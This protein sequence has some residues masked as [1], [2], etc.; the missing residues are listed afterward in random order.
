MARSLSC[1]E[2]Q[3][4]ITSDIFIYYSIYINTLKGIY[5]CVYHSHSIYKNSKYNILYI[6]I[7]YMVYI[8]INKFI[9]V[10]I[11]ICK[12]KNICYTIIYIS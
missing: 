8:Y 11:Y 7:Y 6:Y 1:Q 9:L 12:C 2:S 5:I 3:T 10:Y 4:E